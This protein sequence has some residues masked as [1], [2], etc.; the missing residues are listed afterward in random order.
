MLLA[1]R[2]V[3]PELHS[4]NFHNNSFASFEFEQPPSSD[5][6]VRVSTDGRLRFHEISQEWLDLFQF[7]REEVAGRTLR[8][9]CGPDSNINDIA[10]VIQTA[11]DGKSKECPVWLYSSSGRGKLVIVKGLPMNLEDA[12]CTLEMHNSEAITMKEALCVTDTQVAGDESCRVLVSSRLTIENVNS[13]FLSLF[14][15]AY[16]HVKNRSLRFLN[17]PATDISSLSNMFNSARSGFSQSGT[18]IVYSKNCQKITCRVTVSPVVESNCISSFML[19]LTSTPCSD[20]FANSME[21]EQVPAITSDVPVTRSDI[22]VISCDGKDVGSSCEHDV[23]PPENKV[24]IPVMLSE[25]D[26]MV[27]SMERSCAIATPIENPHETPRGHLSPVA[28][29]T[30]SSS[31]TTPSVPEEPCL[32]GFHFAGGIS[33]S[34]SPHHEAESD[35]ECQGGTQAGDSLRLFPRRKQRDGGGGLLVAP[36]EISV[37]MLQEMGVKSMKEAAQELGIATSTLK[38]ACRRLGIKRWLHSTNNPAPTPANTYSSAYVRRLF[39]KYDKNRVEPS[40]P[41]LSPFG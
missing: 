17:G 8:M 34:V 37:Q 26:D 25:W 2:D 19:T 15:Y 41:C 21:C 4:N 3:G 38:K 23:A 13:K 1:R 32:D 40:L 35:S 5:S 39:S 28:R 20:G 24:K 9:V 36:V 10:V 7:S 14:G 6:F 18:V 33:N 11:K 22:P 12:A 31:E 29:S 16:E 30:V 27:S